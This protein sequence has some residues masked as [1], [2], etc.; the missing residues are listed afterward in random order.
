MA[1]LTRGLNGKEPQVVLRNGLEPLSDSSPND[2]IYARSQW[3]TINGPEFPIIINPNKSLSWFTIFLMETIKVQD[4]KFQ[5]SL[6][7]SI[8]NFLAN[9]YP[10]LTIAIRSIYIFL[11]LST[12]QE[13]D[14]PHRIRLQPRN[15]YL[16]VTSPPISTRQIQT[17][18]L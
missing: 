12:G 15:N 8:S 3:P 4:V 16:T 10:H 14:C 9:I 7:H 2:V 11:S 18:S 17:T 5:I 13:D 6:K 1:T